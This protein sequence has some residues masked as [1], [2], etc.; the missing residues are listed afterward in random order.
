MS[1]PETAPLPTD[2]KGKREFYHSFLK[3][4]TIFVA[5]V[6]VVAAVVIWIIS[7]HH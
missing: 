7:R 4:M 5:H 6:I 1:A 3:I 2:M